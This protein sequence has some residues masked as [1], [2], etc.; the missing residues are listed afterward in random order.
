MENLLCALEIPWEIRLKDID[1]KLLENHD[2]IYC[3]SVEKR[4]IM[5]SKA[6][7]DQKRLLAFMNKIMLSFEHKTWPKNKSETYNKMLDE[8][9][10]DQQE[11]KEF[12]DE[13]NRN[14]TTIENLKR[15]INDLEDFELVE[16]AE[17]RNEHELM[18][19]IRKGSENI[20]RSGAKIDAEKLRHISLVSFRIL[21]VNLN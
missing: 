11:S 12:E 4:L 18:D 10:K 9:N 3:S 1:E 14:K 6:L 13:T 19:E 20:I 7:E 15:A 17:L 8:F 5:K 21:K 16:T 2:E